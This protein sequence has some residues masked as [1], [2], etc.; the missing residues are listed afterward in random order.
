MPI[1]IQI[2]SNSIYSVPES[3]LSGDRKEIE[4]LKFD[5]YI[6]LDKYVMDVKG[7][8]PYLNELVNDVF[9]FKSDHIKAAQEIL[10]KMNPSQHTM[11]SI[12]V[13][14]TDIS[15]HI[16]YFWKIDYTLDDYFERAM[17]YFNEKYEVI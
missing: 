2:N 1:S 16:K 5:H 14:L 7:F 3:T 17:T 9:K 15:D 12:H 4:K 13:R 11:I 6:K 8:Y 10:N